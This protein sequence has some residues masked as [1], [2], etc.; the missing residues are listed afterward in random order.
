MCL[1]YCCSDV[2][3]FCTSGGSSSSIGPIII[4]AS[5]LPRCARP[6]AR[7]PPS[8]TRYTKRS[9]SELPFQL[10]HAEREAA[11]RCESYGAGLDAAEAEYLW[12]A[13]R[14]C[15]NVAANAN[16]CSRF[17]PTITTA[18]LPPDVV[19]GPAPARLEHEEWVY[20]LANP[21]HGRL[22]SGAFDDTIRAV[23][24]DRTVTTR[25]RHNGSVKALAVLADGGLASGS[26]DNT[27]R[28]RNLTRG[29]ESARLEGHTS[30]LSALVVADDG[31][32]VSASHDNTVR[33]WDLKG[34][35]G[36]GPLDCHQGPVNALAA[37][38]DGRLASGSD[39]PIVGFG[40][41]RRAGCLEATGSR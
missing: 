24:H 38:P 8:G 30:W 7:R 22:A 37:L 41:G 13:N 33:V 16:I 6:A 19:R 9:L 34:G 18:S 31:R 39:N 11:P 27:I 35:A 14:C 17:A 32:L 1:R 5:A 25:L 10:H 20:A 36:V 28:L 12:P 2:G 26:S 4:G 23:E 21:G 3:Q 40:F 29:V 15:W